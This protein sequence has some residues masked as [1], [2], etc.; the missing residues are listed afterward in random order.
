MP[1]TLS[2]LDELRTQYEAARRSQHQES[3]V[4]EF[5][6]I[7]AQLRK[8]F[9]WLEKAIAY[10]DGLKP[11]VQHRFE[12]APGIVFEAPR[13]A[14]AFVGQHE[15]RIVGFPVLDEINIS[16]DIAAAKP[17]VI[18]ID[19]VAVTG[20][21]RRLDE[22]GLR[23][24]A[25]RMEDG[26]GITRKCAITVAP[27]IPAS[28]SCRADYRT[29]LVDVALVNVDRLDRITLEFHSRSITEAV[30]EDLVRLI[31]GRSDAFLRS[32]PLVGLHGTPARRVG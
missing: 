12:V 25:R 26:A 15:Q 28:I 23:Y 29:G 21:E 30:L 3:D 31:L 24:S 14:R 2:L 19:P 9:R 6:A 8:A 22:F 18:D 11:A 10:L 5:Q 4:P 16:Y 17:I 7:D 27:V 13:L 32:A 1:E 20:I